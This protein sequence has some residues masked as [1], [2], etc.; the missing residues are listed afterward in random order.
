AAGA[1]GAAGSTAAAGASGA[2]GAGGGPLADKALSVRGNQLVD[3]AGKPVRLLGINRAGSEYMCATAT[4]KSVF[5]GPTDDPN[6]AA[7]LTWH[8][9]TV[10]LPLNESC[11]LGLAGTD[12]DVGGDFYQTLMKDYVDRLHAQGLYVVLDLHW[13]AHGD[14]LAKDQQP[15]ADADHAIALWT[16]V[17]SY[18]KDDPMVVF[19]LF[20]E[21]YLDLAGAGDAWGCWLDGGCDVQGGQAAGMQAMLDAVRGTGAK[22]VVI[23]GGLSYANKLDGWLAHKP[24]DPTGNLMAGFHVYND[25]ACGDTGCWNGA[26]AAVAQQVPIVTGEL[27]ER[28]CNHGFVDGYMSW[29]DAHGVGYLG[30]AWNP[31]DCAKFPALI[32]DWSGSPT[33]FGLGLQTH[34]AAVNP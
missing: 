11:W 9:N 16:S 18:F 34:L 20:N 24:Q 32:S 13:T 2:A 23:A 27:G 19:D 15:M 28:D 30:W 29:A 5:D 31:Q 1:S 4:V 26:V 6:I 8:I 17:A 12:S 33:T 22:Q 10:R 14:A 7:M 25:G 21:P 3:A